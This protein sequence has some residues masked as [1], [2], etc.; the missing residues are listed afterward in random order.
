M[1]LPIPQSLL[2][3]PLAMLN[4]VKIWT[5]SRLIDRI[6][7]AFKSCRVTKAFIPPGSLFAMYLAIVLNTK[8]F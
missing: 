8:E 6:Y 3:K 2:D 7:P 5:L 1:W 4:W